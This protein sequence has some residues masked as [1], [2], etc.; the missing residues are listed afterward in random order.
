MAMF[1]WNRRLGQRMSAY[2]DGELDERR[3]GALGER[4]VFDEGAREE[5]RAYATVDRLVVAAL[6]PQH[7][8]DPAPLVMR[9]LRES[10]APV[11]ARPPQRRRRLLAPALVASMGLLVT[12]GVALVTLRRRGLV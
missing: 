5:L 9:L 3:S 8:P 11:P 6:A 12:A 2:L 10:T 1:T 7:R 4:L